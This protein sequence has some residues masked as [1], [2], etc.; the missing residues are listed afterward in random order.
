MLQRKEYGWFAL[1]IFAVVIAVKFGG[2]IGAVGAGIICNGLYKTIKNKKLSVAKKIGFSSAYVAGGTTLIVVLVFVIRFALSMFFGLTY[3]SE[4]SKYLN[5]LRDAEIATTSVYQL[6][7][8]SSSSNALL[9]KI[10]YIDKENNFQI[11]YP[12]N[13]QVNNSGEYVPVEFTNPEP[14]EVASF[15]VTL[16]NVKNATL[17]EFAAGTIKGMIETGA[18]NFNILNRK[19]SLLS[20]RPALN[21]EITYDYLLSTDKIPMHAV[22]IL[23]L[24]N[25]VGYGLSA[26]AQ[27]AVWSKYLDLFK[28]SAS[29]FSV[30]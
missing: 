17:E 29:S 25:G 9:E 28:A 24:D 6:E 7:Q 18:K 30:K 4:D 21:F 13:W 23:S 22:Y 2:I 10:P 11:N 27:E 26:H 19:E 3:S 20:G 8:M 1:F 5:L 14:D 12:K 15:M 16:D